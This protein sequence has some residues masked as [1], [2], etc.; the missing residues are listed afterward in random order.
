MPTD[1]PPRLIADT[2]ADIARVAGQRQEFPTIIDDH[3]PVGDVTRA[4]TTILTHMLGKMP[5]GLM[6]S[7][8]AYGRGAYVMM[9][10]FLAS[11]AIAANLTEFAA[12]L[13]AVERKATDADAVLR[14]GADRAVLDAAADRHEAM[15]ACAEARGAEAW[16]A[17]ERKVAADV[18]LCHASTHR[19]ALLDRIGGG[20]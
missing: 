19:R 6:V 18:A 12:F 4:V 11:P 17:A 14:A 20:K 3:D 15:V 9:P 10:S 16:E 13:A 1:K 2:A 5:E 8:E 7:M